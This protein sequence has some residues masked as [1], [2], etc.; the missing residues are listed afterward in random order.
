MVAQCTALKA[1][2]ACTHTAA[3]GA[4]LQRTATEHAETAQRPRQRAGL[5]NQCCAISRWY[6]PD[7]E[8][9]QRAA[10][11]AAL[12]VV[13][14]VQLM[15]ILPVPLAARALHFPAFALPNQVSWGYSLNQGR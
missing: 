9:K 1:S 13:V 5:S 11:D 8:P 4:T 15:Q 3:A 14:G 6:Y 7:Y 10:A 12:P 2:G